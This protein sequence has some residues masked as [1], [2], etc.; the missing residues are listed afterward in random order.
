MKTEKVNDNYY[1]FFHN[2]NKFICEGAWSM[3]DGDKWWLFYPQSKDN[4]E[5]IGEAKT[6]RECKQIVKEWSKQ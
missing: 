4:A 3:R 5:F 6:L 2:G 1:Y